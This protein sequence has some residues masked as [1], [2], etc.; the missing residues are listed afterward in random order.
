MDLV[1]DFDSARAPMTTEFACRFCGEAP[2]GGDANDY[3]V[4]FLQTLD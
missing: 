3:N 4:F 2:S 1:C